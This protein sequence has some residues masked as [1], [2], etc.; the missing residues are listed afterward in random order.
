MAMVRTF[1]INM[2]YQLYI[3]PMYFVEPQYMELQKHVPT[4]RL[5]DYPALER[6]AAFGFYFSSPHLG[7]VA[8]RLPNTASLGFIHCR[9]E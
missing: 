6:N 1:C 3:K 5:M 9:F 8:P 7:Q 4:Y 2:V